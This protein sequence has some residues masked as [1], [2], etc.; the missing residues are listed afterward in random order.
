MIAIDTFF[1]FKEILLGL[2]AFPWF[3]LHRQLGVLLIIQF[4]KT[5][6]KF[7]KRQI[8]RGKERQKESFSI[9]WLTPQ[10]AA[11][12]G[13]EPNQRLGARSLLCSPMWEQGSKHLR[14]P[15][16]LSQASNREMDRKR[17]SWDMGPTAMWDANA[18]GGGIACYAT[19][20]GP[21]VPNCWR[22]SELLSQFQTT[23]N[24]YFQRQTSSIPARLFGTARQR[25][26]LCPK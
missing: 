11:R 3:G 22:H 26:G 17:N 13:T 14:H 1:F 9:S 20:P 23:W 25:W 12:T 21:Y 6:L 16:Q 5:C 24:S 18:T 7:F 10:M 4:L 8:Y 2:R 15:L 19:G